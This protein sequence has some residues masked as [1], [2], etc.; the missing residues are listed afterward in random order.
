MWY[1]YAKNKKTKHEEFL[2]KHGIEIVR[3]GLGFSEKEQKW[4]GWS[5]IELYMALELVIR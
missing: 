2:E 1:S 3:T 4:Y 5:H